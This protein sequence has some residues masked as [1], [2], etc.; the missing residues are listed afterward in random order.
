MIHKPMDVLSAFPVRRNKQQK[1]AFRQEIQSYVQ[2]LGYSVT[3][4]KTSFGGTNVIFGD[5]KTARYLVTAHYDTPGTVGIPNFITPCNVVVFVLHQVLLIGAMVVFSIFCGVAAAL[6]L[7]VPEFAGL[8]GVAVYWFLLGMLRFGPANRSNAN[9]NTSGVVTLLSIAGSLPELHRD[10]VCFVLFDLE[11]YGLIGSG[12]YQKAHKEETQKQIVLNLDCVGDGDHILFFPTKKLKKDK[13]KLN[14][15]YTCCGQ[16]GNKFITI[17]DKGFAY[18]PSDQ[19][20]FP[21]GV[22]ITALTKGKLGLKLSRIH[23]KK[24]TVLEQTNVNILRSAL[25]TY[26]T[27]T[28]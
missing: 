4:E 13:R 2:R 5:P 23:T 18:Y 27:C 21:Y 19:N 7:K 11:E 24:D 9:D 10:K 6:A 1:A 3:L 12:S 25:I 16:F 14:P 20:K 22:G 26:I 28:K 17:R 8:I 15:L